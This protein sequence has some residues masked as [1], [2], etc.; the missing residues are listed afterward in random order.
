MIPFNIPFISGNEAHNLNE[1]FSTSK[2]ESNGKF[3]KIC[4]N[5]LE[6]KFSDSKIFLTQSATQAIEFAAIVTG[7]QPG[8]EVIMPSFSYVS[9]AHPF[10]LLGAKIIFV[11]VNP[12]TMNLDFEAV[13]SAITKK[14]KAILVV[15]YGGIAAPVDKIT[16]LAKSKNIVVIEDAAHAIGSTYKNK[17]LGSF[18][19]FSCIS[20]HYTKNI[21]CG[22]GGALIVNNNRYLLHLEE[23]VHNGTNRM[24]FLRGEV[25]AYS[26]TA[27]STGSLMSELNAAFLAAQL[28]HYNLVTK[29]RQQLWEQYAD[30]LN[31]LIVGG[32]ILIQQIPE[33]ATGNGHLFYL[34]LKDE[35]ERQRLQQILEINAIETT[36]HFQPLHLSK[37]GK[38]YG[39]F[40]GQD[41]FTSKDSSRLLRLPMYYD[42]TAEQVSTICMVIRNNL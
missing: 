8:D 22:E 20:F 14:T 13:K 17:P 21:H 11:D 38:L 4:A 27:L 7:I 34:K 35:K 36:F 31:P 40:S 25:A 12:A 26:W 6:K 29:K 1:V 33:Q 32:K 5:L 9:T 24:A 41:N 2:I 39:T 18:G 19:D 15:H 10:V 16:A 30:E 42:L 28:S 3:S 37:A 23:I